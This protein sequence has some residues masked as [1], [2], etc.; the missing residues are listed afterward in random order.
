[1]T[2][3]THSRAALLLRA[4]V[5]VALLAFVAAILLRFP[6]AQYSFYPQCPI[7]HYFGILCPG[8][9]TTRALAAL[10][11][12]NLGEALRLNALT[13]LLLPIAIGYA[14]AG[15]S[16]LLARRPGWP[17]PPRPAIYATLAVAIAFT[18]ARN[19]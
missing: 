2:A 16:R 14:F 3:P 19:L 15:Y 18:L 17:Q 12:G 9:G 4:A 5:P 13:M 1:M 7:H 10:L 8:C 11:H 6:P